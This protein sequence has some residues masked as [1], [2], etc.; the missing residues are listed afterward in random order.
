MYWLL[1]QSLWWDHIFTGL[2]YDYAP[3]PTNSAELLTCAI[4]AR[5][6]TN[7]YQGIYCDLSTL[8][9][10]QGTPAMKW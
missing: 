4:N 3:V 6:E 5:R 9:M 1:I 7:D 2:T 8:L 10:F